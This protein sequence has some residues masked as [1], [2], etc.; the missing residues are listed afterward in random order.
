MMLDSFEVQLSLT[1]EHIRAIEDIDDGYQLAIEA[2]M[3][4]ATAEKERDK[5]LA[6]LLQAILGSGQ[7]VH[8]D[9]DYVVEER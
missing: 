1:P 7:D 6:T 5:K 2:G 8:I 3:D 4:S 9:Y